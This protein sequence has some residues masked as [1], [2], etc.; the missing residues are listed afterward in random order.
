M[1]RDWLNRV[2]AAYEA[3]RS[4]F[5][6]E[7]DFRQKIVKDEGLIYDL[8]EVDYAHNVAEICSR[9]KSMLPPEEPDILPDISHLLNLAN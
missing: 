4:G 5:P 3:V 8:A 2:V 9:Y 1:L 6:Y 7:V